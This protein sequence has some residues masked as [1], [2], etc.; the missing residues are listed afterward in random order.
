MA[1]LLGILVYLAWQMYVGRHVLASL[2]VEWR[3]IDLVVSLVLAAFAYQS[4]FGAWLLMLRRTALFERRYLRRYVRI[5]WVSYMYR[6]VP[7][8]LL[9]L[10]ERARLGA[11][12]GIPYGIGAA[13]PAL[14]TLLAVAAGCA[15]SLLAA[16]YYGNG[17]YTWVLPVAVVPG[18][19]VLLVPAAC[20]WIMRRPA[21]TR[22]YP[23]LAS[24]NLR[25][26]DILVLLIPYVA[27]YVLL[28]LAFFLFAR[29][30]HPMPWSAMPG[31]CGIFA[32]S[33]VAGIIV[34]IAPGGIG[35]REGALAVQLQ[36]LVPGSIAGALAIGIRL[37]FTL[38]E[39]VCFSV[40]Y[41]YGRRPLEAPTAKEA[42]KVP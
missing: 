15:V 22:R 38:A 5:W 3:P 13:M 39:L 41:I 28:G 17:A 35:V 19:A 30:I 21:V 42:N 11:D 37:W 8:K 33:H 32:L 31:L 25:T 2:D 34:L 14:E 24:V 6:Y 10:V 7:G 12:A 4:L 27:H 26:H 40:A 36:K 23:Q 29:G 1:L 9:L 20:R 16:A 18:I